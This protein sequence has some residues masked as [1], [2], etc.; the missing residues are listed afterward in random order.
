MTIIS[1][2]CC[3]SMRPEFNH[4]SEKNILVYSAFPPKK[5]KN[6]SLSLWGRRGDGDRDKGL[7]TS[8]CNT[9]FQFSK[10]KRKKK[11]KHYWKN[12][13]I[14]YGKMTILQ[15]LY[16]VTNIFLPSSVYNFHIHVVPFRIDSLR[17]SMY[18]DLLM[19]L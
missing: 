9:F 5:E 19:S 12:Q 3:C 11:I 8:K 2:L 6:V 18:Q 1:R 4:D 17:P 15:S 14:S 7:H 10:Q 13:K 16:F